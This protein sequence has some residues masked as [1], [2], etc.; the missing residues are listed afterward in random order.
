MGA[1]PYSRL[2]LFPALPQLPTMSRDA[3]DSSNGSKSS[4]P[5]SLTNDE[6]NL[7][8]VG[9]QSNELDR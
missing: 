8:S 3:R 5:S 7:T 6:R 1:A 4:L 9:V 2:K